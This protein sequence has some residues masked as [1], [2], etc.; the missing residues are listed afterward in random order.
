MQIKVCGMRDL[1]NIR[2]VEKL[3]ID[4]LG[5]IFWPKSSRYIKDVIVNAGIIPNKRYGDTVDKTIDKGR[6]PPAIV[7]VF[8]NE[9]PQ[10]VITHAY[11]YRLDYIQLHGD[12][13][14]IYI[15]NLKRT[16]IPDILPHIKIIKTLS[17]HEADD[18]KRW[19]KYKEHVDMFLFDTKSACMGGSGKQ[20]DW[21]ILNNYDGDIPFL[22]SGGIG[23]NDIEKVKNF[24]HP[25]YV[26]IDLNS[27][28]EIAPALKDIEKLKNF[29]N[30]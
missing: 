21:S 15:D 1:N 24:M 17:I 26:G 8:V 25:M 16:I 19:R 5:F 4:Y 20:F 18:I 11:N 2:A 28:F 9:M 23:P 22:L 29:I 3:G 14:P 12:E 13:S 30:P 27:K 6:K 7:G 10:T